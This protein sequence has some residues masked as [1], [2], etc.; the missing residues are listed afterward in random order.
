MSQSFLNQL[1]DNPGSR[2]QSENGEKCI[3]CLEEYDTLNPS[4]GNIECQ[5]RLPCNHGMGSSCLVTWLRTGNNCPVCRAEFFV[6][7]PRQRIGNGIANVDRP[8]PAP[9]VRNR[10]AIEPAP[11]SH[12]RTVVTRGNGLGARLKAIRESRYT[13]IVGRVILDFCEEILIDFLLESLRGYVTSDEEISEETDDIPPSSVTF[14]P[15]R[16]AS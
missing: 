16:T 15:T 8:M 11:A 10:P 1:L 7:E 13:A 3:I 2:V 6:V 4:T 5:V 14:T 9:P 12:S